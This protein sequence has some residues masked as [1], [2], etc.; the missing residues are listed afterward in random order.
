[1]TIRTCICICI[2]IYYQGDRLIAY[3][4]K[5]GSKRSKH[6]ESTSELQAQ[7]HHPCL[8][9]KPITSSPNNLHFHPSPNTMASA[10]AKLKEITSQLEKLTM[11]LQGLKTRI[12]NLENNPSPSMMKHME[13]FIKQS[14]DP[15]SYKESNI[16][17]SSLFS[18]LPK[19][20]SAE[21]LPKFSPT[22]DP[23]FHLKGFRTTMALKGIDPELFPTVFPLSLE[24]VCH[25]WFFSLPEKDTATWEDITHAFMTRYKGNVQTQS[26]SRELEILKQGEQE[27]FTTY[28]G[29]WKQT[30]ATLVSAPA[31]AE[32]VRF[33]YHS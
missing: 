33:T 26:S 6:N 5:Q 31:E 12:D 27:G 2:C 8:S 16:F 14:A 19:K 25:K 7:A 32:M 28:L 11:G 4:R 10:E 3:L 24:P 22:D 18:K 15:V 23:R 21:D 13:K 30:A 20:F 9:S 17:D 1:M 29:R